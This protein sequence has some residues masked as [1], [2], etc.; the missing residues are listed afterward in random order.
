VNHD[1][2]SDAVK[3]VPSLAGKDGVAVPAA[4]AAVVMIMVMLMATLIW[5]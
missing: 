1:G 5:K 4:V 3:I 2:E